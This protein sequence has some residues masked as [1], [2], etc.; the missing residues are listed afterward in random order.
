MKEFK[1]FVG[2]SEDNMIEILCAGLRNDSVAEAFSIR[3]TNQEGL[4]FPT[5]Y[6]KIQPL[7]SVWPFIVIESSTKCRIGRAHGPSF[8]TSIWHIAL[9]GIAD[10][11]YVSRVKS[12]HEE[13]SNIRSQIV[14]FSSL[15]SSIKNKLC[16]DLFLSTSDN[17]DF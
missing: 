12:Q 6:I 9:T 10:E 11:R 14:I 8:H 17:D 5:R 16:F 4:I 13:V 15:S 3:S 2:L 1:V 7:S